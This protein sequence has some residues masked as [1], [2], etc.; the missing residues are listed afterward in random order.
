MVSWD[1]VYY[2]KDKS[3]FEPSEQS[4]AF[5]KWAADN[6]KIDLTSNADHI[7][8]AAQIKYQE[9]FK[10]WMKNYYTG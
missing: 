9:E 5:N 7:V 4:G 2:Y 1:E 6:F 10:A 8:K 3:D